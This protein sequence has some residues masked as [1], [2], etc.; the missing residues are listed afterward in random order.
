MAWFL[1]FRDSLVESVVK[2]YGDAHVSA[3]R[4]MEMYTKIHTFT[5]QILISLLETYRKLE[6]A[7]Q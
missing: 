4:A 3:K 5:D 7:N 6:N 1:F 2:V